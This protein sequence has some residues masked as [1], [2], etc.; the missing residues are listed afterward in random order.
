MSQHLPA[1][2]ALGR[3]WWTEPAR[4]SSFL[5]TLHYKLLFL[6]AAEPTQNMYVHPLPW[7]GARLCY[8]RN[9]GESPT[10]SQCPERREEE[11]DIGGTGVPGNPSHTPGML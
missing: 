7:A 3:L 6:E 11:G 1:E 8:W 10:F 9:A 4:V 5:G 2:A